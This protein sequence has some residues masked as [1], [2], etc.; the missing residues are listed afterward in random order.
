MTDDLTDKRLYKRRIHII[1]FSFI[2]NVD[3][4][5]AAISNMEADKVYLLYTRNAHYIYPVSKVAANN[6]AKIVKSR[7]GAETEC[8]GLNISDDDL[9]GIIGEMRHIIE[10]EA[11]NYI[12]INLA[13]GLPIHS[14]AGAIAAMCFQTKDLDVSPYIADDTDVAFPLPD[15][16]RIE[17][18]SEDLL[19]VL[20]ICN[21]LNGKMEKVSG[22][23]LIKLRE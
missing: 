11:G 23:A 3:K 19:K 7:T 12:Y 20:G 1:P 22:S 16:L 15:V 17:T 21:E 8:R 4:I 6:F 14:I 18:P 13:T 10:S 5:C 9:N 2:D